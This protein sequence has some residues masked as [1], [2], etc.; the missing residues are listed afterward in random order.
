M[1]YPRPGGRGIKVMRQFLGLVAERY[2]QVMHDLI[3]RY[4]SRALILGDRYQSYYYPEVARA[5]VL[6]LEHNGYAVRYPGVGA[7]RATEALT[8]CGLPNIDGG[9]VAAARKK[10]EHNVA[11]LLP[12]VRAGR[13]IV[14][15]GP[16]CGMMMKKEWAGYVDTPEVREVAAATLDLMEFLVTLGKAKTLKREFPG[17]LGTVAYHAACH[18]RAQKIGFPGMR[19]LNVVPG[20]EVRMVEQCSAVDG[21]WGMKA[22]HYETGRKYAQK[23]VD[24]VTEAAAD[25]VVSD[26]TLAG[27]RIAKE[28]GVAVL[29]PVEALARAYGLVPTAAAVAVAGES[30]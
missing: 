24:G 10:I 25:V 13:T 22:E 8:C 11:L 7:E 26:C 6:V 21:T 9:D 15:P 14:T 1:A 27:L 28:N 18:L 2:Y 16:S 17:S 23:L 30:E 5:A 4:D 19:V 12:H 29:H 20:T 3:R